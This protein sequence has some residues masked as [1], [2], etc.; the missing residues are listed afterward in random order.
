MKSKLE[1][2]RHQF[3]PYDEKFYSSLK[4]EEGKVEDRAHFQLIDYVFSG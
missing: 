3:I 4:T 2:L 1:S